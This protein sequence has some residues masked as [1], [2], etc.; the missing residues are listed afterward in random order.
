MHRLA[1]SLRPLLLST[2]VQEVTGDNEGNYPAFLNFRSAFRT[3]VANT[4]NANSNNDGQALTAMGNCSRHRRRAGPCNEFVAHENAVVVAWAAVPTPFVTFTTLQLRDCL[5][6]QHRAGTYPELVCIVPD[7]TR[8]GAHK[9]T[10]VLAS[11]TD[12][13]CCSRHGRRA[14]PCNEFVAHE[15]AVVVAWAAV[16]TPFVTFITL[17]LRDCPL[18]NLMTT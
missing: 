1:E 4:C 15:N 7:L 13:F 16:P 3:D 5:S 10:V 14:G 18:M 11:T 6:R 8:V 9:H 17:Q 12:K 2:V